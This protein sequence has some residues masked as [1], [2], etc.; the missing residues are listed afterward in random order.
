MNLDIVIFGLS[1]TSSWGNGHAATYR[2]LAKALFERGHKVTFLERNVPWYRE[3]RDLFSAAYCRV[4]LYDDL[5]EASRRFGGVV[6]SADLVM[7]GSYVPDGRILADWI[8]TRA[9]GITSFYD[10]DT[11]VTLAALERG[12][13]CY[14]SAALIPRFDLYLSFTGGPTLDII[15][16]RY[17]SPRARELYCAASLEPHSPAST[18]P[19][20]ALG[21][22]GTYSADR[23]HSLETLLIAV[24]RDLPS[25]RFIV[26]G[27]QYPSQIR[28]P[29]NVRR[30]EHLPQ[31]DHAEFY[32]NQRYTLNITREAMRLAGYSPSIRLFEAAAAG[33]PIISDK[34][35]GLETFFAPGEEIL[36]AK[37]SNEVIQ[38]LRDVPEERRREIAAAARQRLARSHTPNQRACQL[39]GYYEEAL[40]ERR[41]GAATI[42]IMSAGSRRDQKCTDDEI[43]KGGRIVPTLAQQQ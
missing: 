34:W 42:P 29:A 25:E 31:A 5:R 20:W 35:P 1:I 18:A 39:E 10:I 6:S 40:T 13:A 11:P 14:I 27:P 9:R 23:Q 12:Q 32:N 43:A 15:E 3:N 2:A 22:L 38:I 4:E 17:G 37:D 8:T 28:W 36:I 19:R 7:L 30:I 21:Y 24:A 41:E 26:A 16:N 33:V